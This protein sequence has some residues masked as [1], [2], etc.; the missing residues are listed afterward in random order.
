MIIRTC[1]SVTVLLI[2]LLYGCSGVE[3]SKS[4]QNSD[5][6]LQVHFERSLTYH[7][8]AQSYQL[9]G[10]LKGDDDQV[11][12][13]V[14]WIKGREKVKASMR[15]PDSDE[16]FFEG[17]T[18][19]EKAWRNGEPCERCMA[20]DRTFD[21]LNPV[22]KLIMAD[23]FISP[24]GS[25]I[26]S[27]YS[28]RIETDHGLVN[29]VSV[30][31]IRYGKIQ[32]NFDSQTGLLQRVEGDQIGVIRYGDYREVLEGK[33]LPYRIEGDYDG[34]YLI[35]ELREVLLDELSEDLFDD[36]SKN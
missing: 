13:V 6:F 25:D 7:A 23:Q 1:Q 24:G 14:Y 34:T 11:I 12:E 30:S 36:P 18:N 29:Q 5:S 4:G 27:I 17:W 33:Y 31:S 28:G 16:P 19:G 21:A 15:H 35:I 32:A 10:Q 22:F 2:L 3:R 20:G 26:E 9:V 8:L